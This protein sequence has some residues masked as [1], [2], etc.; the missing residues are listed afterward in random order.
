MENYA[1]W[2]AYYRTR[3][4][5][6]KT[7]SA[8]AFSYLDKGYRVGFHTFNTPDSAWL[9][10]LDF[11]A[12][13]RASW[14]AK[15][16][17]INIGTGLNT[18]TLDAAL[19][20]GSLFETGGAGGLPV[21]ESGNLPS[22]AKDP[23]TLTCQS[24][25]HILFTDGATHQTAVPA[26][27]G[28][29]DDVEPGSF[30]TGT[31]PNQV[32]PQISTSLG[33]PWYAPFMGTGNVAD[34]L[35]DIATYYWARDLRPA[36]KNDVP[37]WPGTVT[38]APPYPVKEGDGD[39]ETDVAW[40][41]HLNF[42]A[43]SFGAEGILDA[44]RSTD[45]VKDIMTGAATWP[46]P[47]PPNLPTAGDGLAAVDDLWHA[48][49]NARG[50]FVYAEAPIEVAQGLAN[51]LSGI[52]NA[53]AARVGAAFAGSQVLDPANNVVYL[54][55]FDPGW[56]GN[57][58]RQ[59]VDPSTAN[60]VATDWQTRTSLGN[61]LTP[62]T[63][64]D[65][66]WFTNR[67]IVTLDSSG[68][69]VPF[70]HPSDP[71][72]TAGSLDG[73]QL[74][75][76]SPSTEK[77][78]R[79]IAYLRGGST[80]YN[81]VA[82]KT[83]TIEGT[84]IGQFRKR[85]SPLG[86]IDQSQPVV[87][88]PVPSDVQTG[89][90]IFCDVNDPG[91][92]AFYTAQQ[93]R[94]SRI[95]VGA[96]DGM[97][98]AFDAADGHEVFA[99]IPSVLIRDTKDDANKPDGI[100]ALTYQDGG[101]PIFK[102]HAYVNGPLNTADVDFGGGDWHTI[103]VG[104]LGKG[105]GAYYAL[106]VTDPNAADESAAGAK[107]L[108]EFKNADLKYSY[109]KPMI[110]KTRAFG[111]TVIFTT[112]YNSPSGVGKV[113]FV[114][115][116]TGALLA[117]LTTGVG[118][119]TSPSGL[120]QIAGFTKDY[121]NQIVE[122]IYGGD[123]FGNLWRFDVSSADPGAWSVVK[124]AHLTD[125]GGVGQPITTAPQIEIDFANGEDRYV[126]IGTGRL[127]HTDDFTDPV[128]PQQQTMYA[129]RDGSI[130]A[131]QPIVTPID[132]SDLPAL[133]DMNGLTTPSS[134]GWRFDLPADPNERIITPIQADLNVVAFS[135]TQAQNDPCVTS[136]PANLYAR[137][138]ATGRSVLVDGAG[139]LL[140]SFY[141][142]EGAVGLSLVS[143]QTATPGSVPTLK[144]VWRKGKDA[145]SLASIDLKSPVIGSGHRFSFRFLGGQ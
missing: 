48:T 24:N 7:L 43:I 112:G 139:N 76:L 101:V 13:Q 138:F 137:E 60:V 84:S 66:P 14:N 80:F 63:P 1:N 55:N 25:Y 31:P 17:G 99:Y 72:P 8:T 143:V 115:P 2:Y 21:L 131:I 4:L 79:I 23:I 59:V 53:Q 45:Q 140:P 134:T 86:D 10:V 122:Q 49:V 70:R 15:L 19:R 123:L 62:A 121:H 74:G 57:L 81:S 40:W 58:S 47:S 42:S 90:E 128:V 116:K 56:G 51:I 100:Q 61:Q 73:T 126:F 120:T 82:S 65:E 125:A 106:D 97:L 78:R 3:I 104:G 144:L 108:W 44:R 142:S 98:H 109:G 35:S 114:N 54:A 75:T 77:Q 107:I 89:K 88:G 36:M 105:G 103:L 28:K 18:P 136:L 34:S 50:R 110:V 20:I 27:A 30:P 71:G 96:N 145:G 32:L 93:T 83:E 37:S 141:S 11:D 41:Q 9:D 94:P 92:K 95:Y 64:G 132:R 119:P 22:G 39:W 67:R 5:A 12:S 69:P 26:V 127:L 68:S 91:F 113:F 135:G 111:W 130:E 46:N 117:T 87:V 33:G 29:A 102:H 52:A 133:P 129:I 6:A 16:F 118:S 85:Y 38:T 124:F